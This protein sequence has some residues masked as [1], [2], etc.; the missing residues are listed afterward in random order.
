MKWVT[1]ISFIV[2]QCR[3][4]DKI[5]CIDC[6]LRRIIVEKKMFELLPHTADLAIRVFGADMKELFR[7]A[8]IGMFQSAGPHEK[9]AGVHAKDAVCGKETGLLVCDELPES[10]PI[11]VQST[12]QNALLIDF[13]SE[14]LYL[15]DINNVAYLD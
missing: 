4:F 13:L 5:M 14:A 9:T 7:H 3:S 8:L 10:D 2:Y 11:E 1:I 6:F 15:S 12:D